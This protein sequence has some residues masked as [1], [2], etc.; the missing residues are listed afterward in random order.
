MKLSILFE[1]R[2]PQ[3]EKELEPY[4]QGSFGAYRFR[5]P[6]NFKP[7][8]SGMQG[9]LSQAVR[10]H[11][12]EMNGER[13]PALEQAFLSRAATY[14]GKPSDYMRPRMSLFTYL[15]NIKEPWPEGEAMASKFL[16][17]GM[18]K[19]AIGPY[20]G[21]IGTYSRYMSA[22][23][24]SMINYLIN[25]KIYKPELIQAFQQLLYSDTEHE[26]EHERM[27]QAY[28]IW[29]QKYEAEWLPEWEKKQKTTEGEFHADDTFGSS[30]TP[31]WMQD[32][33]APQPPI[34]KWGS[35]YS[36]EPNK[37][38]WGL[39]KRH[40]KHA[41]DLMRQYVDMFTNEPGPQPQ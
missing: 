30:N 18:V 10:Y 19:K 31:P 7:T 40:G 13:W 22:L 24:P 26:A 34:D 5:R 28:P 9:K 32:P 2:D 35:I 21:G 25:K 1:A 12:R 29:K 27:R 8:M 39:I 37:H 16:D 36:Y 14:G 4:L 6:K 41:V 3:L 23:S 20:V 38:Y 11:A 17:S 15:N 33:T